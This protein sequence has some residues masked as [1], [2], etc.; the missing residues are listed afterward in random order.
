MNVRLEWSNNGKKQIKKGL[1]LLDSGA[2]GAVLSS[3]WVRNA[4]LP[5]IRQESPTRISDA[6][7]NHFPS[8]GLHDTKTVD[9]SIGDH[10]NKLRFELADMALGHL[11]G[12]MPMAWLKDH[13]PDINWE[14]GSLKW[15]SDYCKTHCLRSKSRIGFITCEELLSEDPNNMFVCGMRHWTGEDREDRSLKPLPEYQDYPDIF[16]EEKINV[17]PKHNEYDHRIDLVPGSDLPKTR[18]THSLLES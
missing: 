3:A 15:R 4:L 8:S 1:L 2:T 14:R 16:S 10:T 5:C 6:S 13:N 9:V 17:L 7:G 11:D 12:Y 18:Y